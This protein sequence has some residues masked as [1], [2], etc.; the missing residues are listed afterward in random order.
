VDRMPKTTQPISD[1]LSER[2]GSERCL[3][4]EDVQ[5]NGDARREGVWTGSEEDSLCG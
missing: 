5:Y 4:G 2:P 3:I 1:G